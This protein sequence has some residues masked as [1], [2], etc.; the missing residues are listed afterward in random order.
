[1]TIFGLS[2]WRFVVAVIVAELIPVLL[3]VLAMVPVGL[4]IGGALSTGIV[5]WF[6]ARG[7]SQAIALGAVLGLAVAVFDLAWTLA[8]TQGTP[9]RLLFAVS[10]LS[11]L[12]AGVAGGVVASRSSISGG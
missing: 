6:C 3:L 8:A 12:A 1:M 5:A 2:L 10:A 7:N 9:F 4:A 11:R